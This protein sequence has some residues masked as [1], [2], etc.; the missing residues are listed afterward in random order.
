MS[1][2]RKLKALLVLGILS[3]AQPLSAELRRYYTNRELGAR[4]LDYNSEAFFIV[5]HQAELPVLAVAGNLGYVLTTNLLVEFDGFDWV[6]ASTLSGMSLDAFGRQRT[7]SP[8]TLLELQNQYN[9][10]ALLVED[11]VTAGGTATHVPASSAVRLRVTTS[12]DAVVRQSRAYLRYRPGKSQFVALSF[13]STSSDDADVRRRIGYFDT[14][15]GVFVQ[16]V[17]TALSACLRNATADTCVASTLWNIDRMDG[18]GPSRITL[19]ITKSQILLIDLQWL[20]V[21]R[22]R[23]AWDIDGVAVPFHQFLFANTG[24]GVYM[25]TANLPVRYEITATGTIA[26]THD[27]LAICATVQS[28]GGFEPE[29]GY[30]RAAGSV[31]A[32]AVTTRRNVLSIRPKATFN[33][34]VNRSSI[35][36]ESVILT[37][38]TNSAY[39]ELIYNPTLGGIPAWISAGTNSTVEYDVRGTTITGG[40]V[41]A[42]WFVVSGTGAN[43]SLGGKDLTQRLPLTLDQAGATPLVLTVACTSFTGTSNVTTTMNWRELW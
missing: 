35:N 33:S 28:E 43:Q 37:A 15:N 42:G 34:I 40:D 18:A 8:Y 11:V 41:L 6:P 25:T 38:S 14:L 27:L 31:T 10:S 4:P 17:G 9:T 7:S 2:T 12:G 5:D 39:C 16:Q 29:F 1:M 19:D 21:G 22:V 20:G 30:P 36:F 3:L 13:Q 24:T 32:I 26:T 23:L